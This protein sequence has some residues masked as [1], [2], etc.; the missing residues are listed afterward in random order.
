MKAALNT[1]PNSGNWLFLSKP[2]LDVVKFLNV[3]RILS[4]EQSHV[5]KNCAIEN[6]LF[7]TKKK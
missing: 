6:F 5:S 1:D 2:V 7:E 3:V 4:S